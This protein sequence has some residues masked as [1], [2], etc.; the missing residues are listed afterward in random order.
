MS[1]IHK[2]SMDGYN[3]VLDVNGGGVHVLDEV[4]YDLVDLFEEKSKEEIINT[5]S[6]DYTREQIEEAYEEIESLKEE[7]LLFTEDTY[8]E[9]PSFVNRKKVVKALCL[10][11]SHDCNLKCKYCFASQGDFG[12]E[13]EMMSFEVGKKAIDYLIANSGNRRNLEIDFFGG[14]PLMNFDVVKELVAYGRK[15]EKEN[16]KNIRFTITTNG[17]LLDDDKIDYIN[18]HMHNVVLSLDGRQE[19]NDNMRPTV[20]DKGSY[21]VIMPKFKKLVDKRPKD[22]YYYIRGTFTRDNLDFSEDV[23]HFANE[24]FKLTSVE[25][26]VGDE[27]NP[28]ALREEDMDKVFAEYEKL[29]KQYAKR[30]LDGEDFTFF[31]FVVD[32]NQGPCVIKRITGCGAGNEYLAV[33]PNGDIYPCHQFVGNDDFKLA[34]ILDDEVVIPKEISNMFRDAHV[35]SKEDCKTCWNKFYCSG[36]CHANAINFND[37][38]KKPYEL[39]CEMQKKR[40][41]CS[42]MIQAKLMLEGE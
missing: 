21:D 14:E 4:A 2:F 39:G 34:N 37:D 35:Y 24:G 36:G 9:H 17:V 38:I 33:T 32:L 6:K 1:M 28:Y 23:F 22:K 3:I 10:H 18:E 25:P 30:K 42:I 7:G 26:V 29:A 20:N 5:L 11:V 15:V 13:K 41:E 27:S 31:H 19:I 40:T 12:G 16:G 8:Q